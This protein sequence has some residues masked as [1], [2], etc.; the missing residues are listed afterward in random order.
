M[1][2]REVH[3]K[4]AENW[5]DGFKAFWELAQ[6]KWSDLDFS[7]IEPN[8]ATAHAGSRVQRDEA[9]RGH[10]AQDQE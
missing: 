5:D 2:N 8:E 9:E 10:G 6:E 4:I 3:I 7:L 1:A